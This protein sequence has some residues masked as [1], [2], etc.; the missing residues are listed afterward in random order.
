MQ[1]KINSY[2]LFG[3]VFIIL[4]WLFVGVFRDDEF[5]EPDIFLKY[6]PTFKIIFHSPVGMQD[7]QLHELSP[8]NRAEEIAFRDFVISHYKIAHVWYIPLVLIQLTLTLLFFGYFKARH[9]T[10][11]K[12]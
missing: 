5:Y 11:F 4:T 2:L 12:K 1:T 3:T 8:D 9:N 6:R 7:I 10:T